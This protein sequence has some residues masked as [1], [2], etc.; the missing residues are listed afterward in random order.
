MFP[1][2]KHTFLVINSVLVLTFKRHVIRSAGSLVLL[3]RLWVDR[4]IL[5]PFARQ[6]CMEFLTISPIGQYVI[7]GDKNASICS[8]HLLAN[9]FLW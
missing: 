4:M 6:I 1:N 3:L 8:E 7:L 9:P 5:L 2:S